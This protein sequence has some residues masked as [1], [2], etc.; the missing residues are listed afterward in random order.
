MRRIG[1]PRL[2]LNSAIPDT[3]HKIEVSAMPCTALRLGAASQRRRRNFVAL[4]RDQ[5]VGLWRFDGSPDT[6]KKSRR[7]RLRSVADVCRGERGGVPAIE[8]R[9]V[10][11]FNS[12]RW[13]TPRFV[14]IKVARFR[15]RIYRRL[16]YCPADQREPDH[17]LSNLCPRLRREGGPSKLSMSFIRPPQQG[18]GGDTL[19]QSASRSTEVGAA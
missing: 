13:R 4:N 1:N 18:Q 10:S 19:V 11:L 2:P 12:V 14:L 5:R 3:S 16:L 7:P 15:C 17:E 6:S 9:T 8:S